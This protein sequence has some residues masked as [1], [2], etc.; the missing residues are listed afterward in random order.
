MGARR[1]GWVLVLLLAQGCGGPPASPEAQ[2]PS[3]AV[4]SGALVTQTWPVVMADAATRAPY[5]AHP[6]WAALVMRR[7]YPAALQAFGGSPPVPAGQARAHLEMSAALRQAAHLAARATV[8]LWRDERREEDPP[9][10]DCVVGIS[11]ILLGEPDRAV[12]SLA[13]CLAG[14]PGSLTGPAAAWS[15]WLRD[16]AEWPPATPLDATPGAVDPV[17]PGRLPDLATPSCHVF[18]DTVEGREVRVADPG[19]LLKLAL[20]HEAAARQAL[21]SADGA[22]T[23]LLAPWRLPGEPSVLAPPMPVPM[24]CLFGSTL[25]APGD[26]ALAAEGPSDL[27]AWVGRSPI[28]AVIAPCVQEG[29]IR[30]D[31]ANDRAQGLFEQLLAAMRI[32]GGGEQGFHRSFGELARL[33]VL[34]EAERIAGRAGDDRAMGLLRLHAVDFSI[35]SAAEPAYLLSVAAWN[36]GNKNASRAADLLHAQEGRIPGVEVARIPLDALQV[37]IGRESAPGVPMH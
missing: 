27:D 1:A 29:A 13:T 16:S 15:R 20:W 22:I 19:V 37:R 10:V 5:E 24:E 8:V 7:D 6:G 17:T 14:A 31:C 32:R 18:S 35:G 23:L 3:E 12:G 28:A 26:A 21:P 33:G 4:L 11:E 36:A 34:R 9:Q 30:V 2:K 25:L